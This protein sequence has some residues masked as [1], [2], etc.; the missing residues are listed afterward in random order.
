MTGPT[1]KPYISPSQINT[2]TTCAEAW[3][4]RYVEKHIIPPGVA[5]LRGTSVHR[6]A[7][8]NAVQ[9]MKSHEDLSASDIMA[10][11]ASAFDDNVNAQGV[12]LSE[13]EESVGKDKVLGEAKDL[14][15]GM[16]HVFAKDVAPS[17]QPTAV[18]LTQEISLPESTHD[19]KGIVDVIDDAENVRDIKTSSK[20][21]SQSDWDANGQLT[22]YALTY[23]AKFGKDPKAVIVD[24]L[25]GK[26]KGIEYV[27]VVTSRTVADYKP[28]V[29][30]INSVIAGI[31]AGVFVPAP[32]GSWK[33]SPKWCGYWNSCLYVNN[34]RKAAIQE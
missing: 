13:E 4:R 31:N 2:Y 34:E 29:H 6:G 9:K 27:P 3:R 21:K 7:E 22:F 11:A 28:L 33:C 5:E 30:R 14:A 32:T 12:M 18:E 17:V 25:I 24:Q 15:V 10:A 19:L 26:K 23:R 1:K 16:A 20:A 8:V